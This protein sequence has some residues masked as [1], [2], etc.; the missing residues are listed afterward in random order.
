MTHAPSFPTI[1]ECSGNGD[2]T[3][4][5][6]RMDVIQSL[7]DLLSQCFT[8]GA[9]TNMLLSCTGEII[10]P[11]QALPEKNRGHVI[12]C[13]DSHILFDAPCPILASAHPGPKQSDKRGHSSSIKYR[14]QLKAQLTFWPWTPGALGGEEPL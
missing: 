9:C 8:L 14:Q 12:W 6:L 1:E 11:T 4:F 13:G 5:Q 2:L 7:R 3:A 10:S